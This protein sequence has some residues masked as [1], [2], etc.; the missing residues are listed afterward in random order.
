MNLKGNF[1]DNVVKILRELP[2]QVCL[3]CARKSSGP[4]PLRGTIVDNV[5]TGK[6]EKAFASR[7]RDICQV[8]SLTQFYSVNFSKS[9][10]DVKKCAFST[11]AQ[12]RFASVVVNGVL[13][14]PRLAR[15]T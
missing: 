1:H 7:V 13:G 9:R 5:D 10:I 8:W 12:S 15:H 6:S 3:V 4:S 2:D 14:P 11:N